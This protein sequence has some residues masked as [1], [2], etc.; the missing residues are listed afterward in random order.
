MSNYVLL[1]QGGG[2]PETEEEQQKVMEAWGQWYEGMGEAV[3]DPGAPLNPMAKHLSPD[4]SVGDLN[5]GT[6][7]SGYTIIKADSM[8][9]ALKHAMGCPIR[10][11]GGE[12]T[13]YEA[14]EM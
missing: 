2:M 10:A 8:D 4:D 9:D 3:V 12:V 1:Y 14:W 6:P 13:V 5:G 7:F 11:D